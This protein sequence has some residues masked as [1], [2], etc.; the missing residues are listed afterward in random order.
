MAIRSLFW[1]SI[2]GI[3]A[4]FTS[5]AHTE[6]SNN[7]D[8]VRQFVEQVNVASTSFF[9]SGSAA[10]ARQKCR[11]LLSWAFDVPAMGEAV[12]DRAWAS[13][14]EKDRKDFLAAFEDEILSEYLDRMKG[15]TT[16]T[17]IG[18]RAPDHGELLAA[19]RVTRPGKSDQTWIWQ[20][21]P[22]GD[23]WRIVDLLVEGRS[24]ILAE[25]ET[26][27]QVLEANHGHMKALI[28]FIRSRSGP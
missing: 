1:A 21:R 2:F 20:I 11:D 15:G 13:A 19:S 3:A 22:E 14:T 4:Q 7:V 24:A 18:I 27:S 5:P 17:F 10:D 16:M 26:Y 28:D 6:P 25:R 8:A 9:A 12:L 23:Q